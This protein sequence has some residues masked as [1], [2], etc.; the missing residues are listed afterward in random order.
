MTA[1][2]EPIVPIPSFEELS[3]AFRE[4]SRRASARMGVSINSLHA[5]AHSEELGGATRDFFEAVARLTVLPNELRLLIRLA[6]ATAN[7]C[8]YCTAHQRHQ[9]AGLGVPE[10]KIAAIWSPAG[11]GLSPRERAAI[12]FAQSIAID[13]GAIP[14]DVT[15]DLMR[16]FTP[17]ERI[18]VAIVATSMDMLNKLNDALRVPLEA[19]FAALVG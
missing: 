9:L 18:E 7:Q 14:A 17:Q 10:Q 4:R 12:R 1:M 19:E 13:A 5:F 2:T 11:D 6:V 8:R 3:S 16:E 15:A